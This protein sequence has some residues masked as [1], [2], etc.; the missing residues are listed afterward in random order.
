MLF[1]PSV[2]PFSTKGT[3]ST[4]WFRSVSLTPTSP[5]AG[6]LTTVSTP[7]TEMRDNVR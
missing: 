1:G 3:M 6:P 7:V 5:A 4:L 2:R